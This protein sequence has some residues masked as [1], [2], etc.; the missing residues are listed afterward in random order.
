MRRSDRRGLLCDPIDLGQCCAC[1]KSGP[2]VRNIVML[3]FRGPDPGKGWGCLQC[4]LPTDG[5]SAVLCD[6]CAEAGAEPR[7]IV[8][9][10]YLAT[11]SA[12]RPPR[13]DPLRPRHEQAPRGILT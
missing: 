12:P 10:G 1:G 7:E 8:A 3:S 5:A 4:G 11:S 9:A 13:P 6:G 2:D